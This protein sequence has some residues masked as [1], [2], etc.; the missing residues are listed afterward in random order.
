ML[1]ALLMILAR[2]PQAMM[3]VRKA[4]ISMS[5]F[6]ENSCGT[7]MGSLAMNWGLLYRYYNHCRCYWQNALMLSAL[8]PLPVLLEVGPLLS[9]CFDRRVKVGRVNPLKM[10]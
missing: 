7:W 8:R 5:S 6:L 4:A 9:G 3:D 10:F 2:L 1:D